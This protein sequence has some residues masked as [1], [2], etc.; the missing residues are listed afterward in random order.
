MKTD[1]ILNATENNITVNF[2][3]TE[4]NEVLFK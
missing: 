2:E 3:L 1:S 4:N